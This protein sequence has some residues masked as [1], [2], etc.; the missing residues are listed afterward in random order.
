MFSTFSIA[1]DLVPPGAEP[2]VLAA[3][4]RRRGAEVRVEAAVD[5]AGR[6]EV[7]AAGGDVFKVV[8]HLAVGSGYCSFS[9]LSRYDGHSKILPCWFNAQQN[10]LLSAALPNLPLENIKLSFKVT[11]DW[12]LFEFFF[13]CSFLSWCVLCGGRSGARSPSLSTTRSCN[14]PFFL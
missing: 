10:R 5:V 3:V 6:G 7:A 1:A 11:E 14:Q 2:P 12:S 8:A 9:L 4:S 13:H